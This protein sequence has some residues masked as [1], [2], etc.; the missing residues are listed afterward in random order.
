MAAAVTDVMGN[1]VALIRM[2]GVH[3]SSAA[4]ALSKAYTAAL[5]RSSTTAAKEHM[6]SFPSVAENVARLHGRPII[7][8]GGGEP[9]W[10][11]GRLIGAIGVS[12]GSELEDADCAVLGAAV[13]K[14]GG[15]E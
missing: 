11:G 3:W 13:L 14:D 5:F 2:D 4:V 1:P 7:L 15:E 12:G 8:A 6:L 10:G 9:L